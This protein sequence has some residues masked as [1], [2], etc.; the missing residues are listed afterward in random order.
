M[1]SRWQGEEEER[2]GGEG[3]AGWQSLT[4][5]WDFLASFVGLCAEGALRE[6]GTSLVFLLSSSFT[7]N[8]LNHLRTNSPRLKWF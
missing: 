4:E 6:T 7:L 3:G 5:P 2:G 1:G 8:R